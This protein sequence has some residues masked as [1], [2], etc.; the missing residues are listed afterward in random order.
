[1]RL[2]HPQNCQCRIIHLAPLGEVVHGVE[3][4]PDELFSIFVAFSGSGGCR[5]QQALNSPLLSPLVFRFNDSVGLGDDHIA[6]VKL[7][8]SL[9]IARIR[10][11]SNR[12][13]TR[14]ERID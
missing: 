10:K 7:R 3:N 13:S 2:E 11:H 9:L 8:D 14:L 4:R 1:M 12:L 5:V 6:G